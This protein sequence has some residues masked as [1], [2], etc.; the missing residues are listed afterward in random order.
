MDIY[1][2]FA[3]IRIHKSHRHSC[4]GINQGAGGRI[5]EKISSKTGHT[6]FFSGYE[7]SKI[8]A[9]EDICPLGKG[10]IIRLIHFKSGSP[11]SADKSH[12]SRPS[13]DRDGGEETET[14]PEAEDEV[15]EFIFFSLPSCSCSVPTHFRIRCWKCPVT[16]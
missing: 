15:R 7:L 13:P 4:W 10:I 11:L 14:A 6:P 1:R 9:L 12:E 8:Y 16:I 5:K 2:L 3:S